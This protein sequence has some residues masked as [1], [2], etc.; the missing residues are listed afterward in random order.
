MLGPAVLRGSRSLATGAQDPMDA[1][2]AVPPRMWNDVFRGIG[3]I[4]SFMVGWMA[5][6]IYGRGPFREWRASYREAGAG[7]F[8]IKT[9]PLI[10]QP[11]F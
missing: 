10:L 8:K 3:G 5:P 1:G 2:R 9:Q 6:F 4:F 11:Y 7:C